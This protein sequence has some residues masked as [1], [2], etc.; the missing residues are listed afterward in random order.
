MKGMRPQYGVA[1]G[2]RTEVRARSHSS[3]SV[4]TVWLDW[5][6]SHRDSPISTDRR[7]GNE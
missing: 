2:L 6:A 4:V 5:I 1:A 3:K 7:H